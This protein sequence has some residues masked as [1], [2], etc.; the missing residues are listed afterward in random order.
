MFIL[1]V[2]KCLPRIILRLSNSKTHL[3]SAL[4]KDFGSEMLFFRAVFLCFVHLFADPRN[5]PLDIWQIIA[6]N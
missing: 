5:I 6:F 2:P 4:H 3:R 1:I